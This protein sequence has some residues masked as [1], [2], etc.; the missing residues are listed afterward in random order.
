MAD[1]TTVPVPFQCGGAT[2]NYSDSAEARIAFGRTLI[3][4]ASSLLLR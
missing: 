2:A 1:H 3:A 4:A